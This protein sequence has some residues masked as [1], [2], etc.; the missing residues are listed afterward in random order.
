M[1]RSR[2][3]TAA[4]AVLLVAGIGPAN[5]CLDPL[6]ATV[7]AKLELLPMPQNGFRLTLYGGT[8]F[9]SPPGEACG[10]AVALPVKALLIADCAGTAVRLLDATNAFNPFT[11]NATTEAEFESLMM[12]SV[13]PFA[14]FAVFGFATTLASAIADGASLQLEVD[15]EC[16]LPIDDAI[17]KKFK[18]FLTNSGVLGTGP[19][20]PDG[21]I[22]FTQPTHIG[23][24]TVSVNEKCTAG[25]TKCVM[26]KTTG[27]LQCHVKAEAT[28]LAVD[29]SCITK[30]ED[31]FDGGAVP[32]KG[33]FEK[34]EAK[35]GCMT[36]D[37]TAAVETLVDTFVD[38]IVTD[39]DPGYPVPVLNAC[40]SRK[41]NCV[42]TFLKKAL[43]CYAKKQKIGQPVDPAC[44]S[45][46]DNKY[47]QCFGLAEGL[48]GCLTVGDEATVKAKVDAYLADVSCAVDP[49]TCP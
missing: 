33:C 1:P 37:D 3:L 47:S 10:C 23:I 26:K 25:K 32:T 7:G 40:S 21:T 34:L 11:P 39:L 31:K 41:K 9:G 6:P 16:S 15:F 42:R 18:P 20:N 29:P 44:L 30:A 27:L 35:G 48:G 38:D 14:G 8:A 5:A 24:T 2:L 46:A 45:G 43:G 36:Q 19:L 17:L 12:S 28:G 4:V 49:S 22:D 13:P